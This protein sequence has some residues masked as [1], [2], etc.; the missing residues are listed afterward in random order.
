MR[1]QGP[2]ALYAQNS[3]LHIALAGFALWRYVK[4]PRERAAAKDA[5]DEL[6]NASGRPIG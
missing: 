2:G 6:A 3:V 4:R 1:D 5:A